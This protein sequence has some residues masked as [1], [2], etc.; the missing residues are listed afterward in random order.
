M[1]INAKPTIVKI[2]TPIYW[3]MICVRYHFGLLV[4]IFCQEFHHFGFNIIAQTG[5]VRPRPINVRTTAPSTGVGGLNPPK[6]NA[7]PI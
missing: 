1:N 2:A 5:V 6:K 4:N 3:N 7:R